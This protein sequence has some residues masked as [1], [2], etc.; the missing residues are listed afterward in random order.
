MLLLVLLFA[1]IAVLN[2]F[3]ATLLITFVWSSFYPKWLERYGVYVLI[4]SE[5]FILARYVCSLVILKEPTENSWLLWTGLWTTYNPQ[6]AREY[7]RFPPGVLEW[8]IVLLLFVYYRRTQTLGDNPEQIEEIKTKINRGLEKDYPRTGRVIR[9][10]KITLSHLSPL[11]TFVL[12]ALI[13][14]EQSQSLKGLVS[15][16]LLIFMLYF[17]LAFGLRSLS[18]KWVLI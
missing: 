10:I 13:F 11:L 14:G 12:L 8:S 9:Y 3:Q 4:Y 1:G 7:W 15:F 18:G 16:A 2:A 6:V 17:L 5:L